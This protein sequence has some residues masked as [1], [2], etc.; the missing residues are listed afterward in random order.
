MHGLRQIFRLVRA[1]QSQRAVNGGVARIDIAQNLRLGCITQ[2]FAACD[3]KL[4]AQFFALV[5]VEDAQRN[6]YADSY[7][8]ARKRIV[9]GRIVRLPRGEGWIG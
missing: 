6:I 9:S 2:F 5:A 1:Q 3:I 4:G 8:L 7:S